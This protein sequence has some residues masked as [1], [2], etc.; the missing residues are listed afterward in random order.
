MEVTFRRGPLFEAVQ[1]V[2]GVLPTRTPRP[3]LQCLHMQVGEEEAVLSGTDLTV[4]VRFQVRV[5]ASKEPGTAVMHGTRLSGLLRDMNDEKV[6]IRIDGGRGH[7]K[8][9]KS[10]FNLVA[11]DPATYP[12]L[13]EFGEISFALAGAEVARMAAST[14]FAAALEQGRYAMNSV[15]VTAGG[16]KI[17]FAA[18]DGRRLAVAET[19]AP[20]SAKFPQ[21]LLPPKMLAEIRRLAAEAENVEF[22]LQHGRMLARAGGVL[23]A[24]S[25]V[26]GVF[27]AYGEMIP[28]EPGT[29]LKGKASVL[30]AKI[31]Q[32]AQVTTD[33]ARVVALRVKPGRLAV[34]ARSATVG[35]GHVECPVE[36]EG[37]EMSIGFN[38]QF[39]LDA[40]ALFGDEEMAIE[41]AGADRPAVIRRKGFTYVA[42]PIRLPE[43]ME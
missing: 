14:V 39:L 21:S 38:P 15:A 33:E 6:T 1:A 16:G 9:G 41:L 29:S 24:G 26:E 42:A 10:K 43:E 31:R 37:E 8:A 22:G 36:Y 13:P 27:P 30:A 2:S 17:T 35:E 18:T 40:L 12:E 5:E 19:A 4:A 20:K 28:K 23:V 25:L 3:V 7:L 32:A 11:P 34:E